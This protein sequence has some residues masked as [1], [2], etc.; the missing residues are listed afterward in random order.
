MIKSLHISNFQSHKSTQLEF[1]PG[2]NVIIGPSDS[3][4]SAILRAISWA[5]FNKPSGDSFR[6]Y[7]EGNTAVDIELENETITREK[8]K[9]NLYINSSNKLKKPIEFKAFGTDVPEEIKS[10]LNISDIN[11]QRQMD[12]PF[13]LSSTAGEVGKEL[14]KAIRLDIIDKAQ[15]NISSVL[16]QEKTLLLNT[17]STITSKQDELEKYK[18]LP[19]AEGCVA[20]LENLSRQISQTTRRTL[21]L[22]ECIKDI[23]ILDISLRKTAV[24]LSYRD[25]VKELIL[26]D[27][28]INAQTN[29]YNDINSVKCDLVSVEKQIKSLSKITKAEKSVDKLEKIQK[30]YDKLDSQYEKLAFAID[31]IDRVEDELQRTKANNNKLQKEFELRMPDVCVL[32]GQVIDK[33]IIMNS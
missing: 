25:R 13:L 9:E 7:W 14:N 12:A 16:R 5:I 11:I 17:Q 27:E 30:N 26:F 33:K 15:K 2:V 8:G 29:I 31:N 19:V 18:W 21:D 20:K 3:G 10:V 6:S 23:N 1:S 4:K 28:D 32:C 22:R 24:I